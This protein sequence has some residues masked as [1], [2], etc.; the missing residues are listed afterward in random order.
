VAAITSVRLAAFTGIRTVI[1]AIVQKTIASI[2]LTA[3]YNI[4]F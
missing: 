4:E 2:P 3:N 1:E